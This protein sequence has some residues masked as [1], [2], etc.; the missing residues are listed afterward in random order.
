MDT[1][2]HEDTS[3][4]FLNAVEDFN[5][6]YSRMNICIEKLSLFTSINHVHL[7][8]TTTTMS[9]LTSST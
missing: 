1:F 2:L 5:D 6:G 3:D 4:D 7:S 9:P 8:P